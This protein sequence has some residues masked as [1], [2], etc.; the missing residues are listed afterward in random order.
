L[1]LGTVKRGAGALTDA[2]IGTLTGAVVGVAGGKVAMDVA[3]GKTGTGDA[4]A[5]GV[6]GNR[7]EVGVAVGTNVWVAVGNTG[8]GDAVGVAVT[9]AEVGV[10]ICLVGVILGAAEGVLVIDVDTLT[11]CRSAPFAFHSASE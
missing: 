6:G 5:V 3:V 10:N 8:A 2:L 7:V 4:V 1:L 11:L 9:G